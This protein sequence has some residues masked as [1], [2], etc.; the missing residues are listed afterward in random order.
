MP[1]GTP[2]PF[3][4]CFPSKSAHDDIYH[5]FHLFSP[6]QALTEMI[7][8]IRDAIQREK[9]AENITTKQVTSLTNFRYI[10]NGEFIPEV[11]F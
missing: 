8:D 7:P 9:T 2:P 11:T 6:C 3:Q 10:E 1:M 4:S 5:G